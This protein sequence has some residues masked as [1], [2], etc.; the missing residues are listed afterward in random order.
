VSGCHLFDFLSTN[1]RSKVVWVHPGRTIG[2]PA[3][4]GTTVF[5]NTGDHHIEALDEETGKQLW[6][7]P[8]MSTEGPPITPSCVIV[9]QL[10]VCG[11]EDIVAF[12]R[13]T[14]DVVWRYH[15]TLGYGPGHYGIQAHHGIVFAGSNGVGTLGTGTMYALDGSSG[16]PLWVA[17]PLAQDTGGVNIPSVAA[18]SDIVAGAFVVYARRET[19]GVVAL[20]AHTG[21]VRWM[22]NFPQGGPDSTS[23]GISV[24]FW[25]A[26]VMAS[27]S[28][29]KIYMLDRATG[30][31]KS[32]FPGVGKTGNVNGLVVPVGN[33]QRAIVVSGNTLFA[34]SEG[35]WFVAYDLVQRRELWRVV[36]PQG[37]ANTA[38]I[39]ADGGAVYVVNFSGHVNA[40]SATG[41]RLLWDNGDYRNAFVGTV[42]VGPKRVFVSGLT[43]AWALGK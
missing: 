8:T 7:A 33:D 28:D 17:A 34:D 36:I 23:A 29:G 12:Q 20:D 14:G 32:F 43:G 24:A 26:F 10:V 1:D 16:A 18:D 19:G 40:F 42:A 5:F 35:N 11:D 2:T 4:D 38:P 37:S 41:P 39:V 9:S 6:I 25:G 3:F 22:T 27:S 13:A 30:A 21:E 31:I 15:A